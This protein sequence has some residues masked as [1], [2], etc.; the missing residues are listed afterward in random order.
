MIQIVALQCRNVGCLS[1][2]KITFSQGFNLVLGRNEA[3]K[4]TLIRTIAATL[5]GAQDDSLRPVGFTGDYGAAI[6]ISTPD[7]DYILDRNFADNR[8]QA[9]TVKGT[10]T[11]K[12]FDAKA[13][14][15]GRSADVVAWFERLREILGV[16]DRDLFE[17][18]V[19]LHQ[20]DL[21]VGKTETVR[22]IKQ[23][24]AGQ[25]TH[26]YDAVI[27][28]LWSRYFE[29]TSDNPD[30]RNKIKSREFEKAQ[31]KQEKL[32]ERHN[33][34]REDFTQCMELKKEIDRIN[35]EVLVVKSKE[36]QTD[37][38]VKV[39]ADY[40]NNEDEK[41][42]LSDKH[43]EFAEE[44]KKILDLKAKIEVLDR[45]LADLGL[46]GQIDEQAADNMR[47]RITLD[48]QIHQQESQVQQA[49]ADCDSVKTE[50]GTAIRITKVSVMAAIVVGSICFF[51]DSI[52][53][54]GFGFMGLAI[55]LSFFVYYLTSNR[56]TNFAKQNEILMKQDTEL[57]RLTSEAGSL[58]IP[59]NILATGSD[60]FPLLLADREKA[61][62]IQ[63]EKE[64][65]EAQLEVLPTLQD[66]D[67][68][69]L[70]IEREM[71][72]LAQQ[73][74]SLKQTHPELASMEHDHLFSYMTRLN[75]LE[76]QVE[77]LG[78]KSSEAKERYTALAATTENP[79][80]L[81]E[82]IEDISEQIAKLVE[83]KDAL[84]LAIR[85]VQ[86]SV[87]EYRGEYLQ[88]FSK[89]V[90][91]IFSKL[92]DDESRKVKLDNDLSPSLQDDKGSLPIENLSAGTRDQ[93]YFAARLSLAQKLSDDRKLPL[94][95]DDPLVN[96]DAGRQAH[97]IDM[98]V[99]IAADHQVLLFSHD[100]DLGEM[101][102]GRGNVLRLK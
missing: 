14:P 54:L 21:A 59:E 8:L 5:F 94:I 26:D 48:K 66:A 7:G 81:K 67:E 87:K 37:R 80:T 101:L 45:Q 27:D 28:G 2:R 30:G 64:R 69:L 55:L 47:T 42:Q 57:T 40:F 88:D 78:E 10:S 39:A 74:D 99:S 97:T 18:S 49:R 82:Q 22:K 62:G 90:D 44:R 68:A 41:D 36:M 50:S 31:K 34:A 53:L 100:E 11:E 77:Q 12:I 65:Y 102:N 73:M 58:L 56:K 71:A 85:A 16:S 76:E 84:L 96:F 72:V 24:L 17:A 35:D 98:L 43:E 38:L 6:R 91:R 95:L 1:D 52:F 25:A 46:A 86:M 63:R 89:E 75:D 92:I 4:S 61:I 20:Q 3:G 13:S 15:R 60:N 93:L 9:F 51:I 19:L 70:R 79:D 29:V 23:I 33:K 32:K 83:R